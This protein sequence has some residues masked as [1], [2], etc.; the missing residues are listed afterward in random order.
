MLYKIACFP[1]MAPC[2][3]IIEDLLYSL[4]KNH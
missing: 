4:S 3:L 1:Y 2:L